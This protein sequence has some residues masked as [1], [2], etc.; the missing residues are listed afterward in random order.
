MR[1]LAVLVVLTGVTP[2]LFA[3]QSLAIV[4]GPVGSQ[5]GDRVAAAGSVD[6]DAVPDWLVRVPNVGNG[7][8]Q[9]VSGA[10]LSVRN[11]DN[12]QP[13]GGF[14]DSA[15]FASPDLN[16]DGV[17]DI[18]VG[19]NG[20]LV[21]FSG[22]T[23]A[24]LWQTIGPTVY[25][26]ACAI[27]DI[28]GDG[29][30]DLAAMSSTSGN[31]TLWT[32]R[33]SNGSAIDSIPVPFTHAIVNLGDVTGDGVPEI[34]IG[35]GNGG[36]VLRA[37]P[38]ASLFNLPGPVTAVGAA[39]LAGD[40]RNEVL[41][42]DG[43]TLRVFAGGTSSVVRTFA[44]VTAGFAVVGDL[45]ADGVP[46]LA[47]RAGFTAT[48]VE[49]A[50]L[51]SGRT[52]A[53]L[54]LWLGTL[55]LRVVQLAAV[56][57]VD[58]DGFGEL[59]IGDPD[60][61]PTWP[62]GSARGSWQLLSCKLLATMAAQPVNCGQGPFLPTLGVTRPV[63]GMPATVEGRDAPAGAVGFLAFSPQPGHATN[64]GVVGCDAWFDPANGILLHQPTGT[65]WQFTFPVPA[66]PQLAGFA[67]ALQAFYAPTASPIGLDVSNGIW[68]RAGY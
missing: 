46:D 59:L 45:D 57:D 24:Q 47:F 60:A 67:F 36:S 1:A 34:A 26:A 31:T 55:R 7:R 37:Q 49:S 16:Q 23:L 53:R 63:L 21:A 25:H 48:P 50:E 62:L 58:G 11:L 51:V 40:A 4:S 12:P 33:G 56:G 10:N 38:L 19:R 8:I 13:G 29:R 54:A 32:L 42:S 27:G 68:A 18:V 22:A 64:L 20:A 44:N 28:D 9:V 2:G 43:Q 39:D 14:G 66:V 3:Q 61:N 6:G 41:A 52:G 30:G 35:G 5:T 15:L 17:R 65:S